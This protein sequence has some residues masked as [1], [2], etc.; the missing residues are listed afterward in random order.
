MREVTFGPLARLEMAVM[1]AAPLSLLALVTLL[2]WPAGLLPLL[3]LVWG[4][5]LAVYLAFPLYEPL[6]ARGSL[7]GF[8][9]LFAG[10]TLAGVALTGTLADHLSLP[11]FALSAFMAGMTLFA[12]NRYLDLLTRPLDGI[13]RLAGAGWACWFYIAKALVPVNLSM[14]Y[15][16]WKETIPAAGW[17]AFFPVWTLIGIL[18]LLWL[19]S[20]IAACAVL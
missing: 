12:Q 2:F 8:V 17:F 4:L 7:V 14:I 18:V 5:A 9:A 1:W 11:F 20:L 6:V 10:L 13:Y 19:K 15:P 16:E 3:A